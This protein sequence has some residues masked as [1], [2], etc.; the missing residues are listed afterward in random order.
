MK[1]SERNQNF[2]CMMGSIV[3]SLM[4]TN[5]LDVVITKMAA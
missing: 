2:A 5:P 3:L 1:G 4:L